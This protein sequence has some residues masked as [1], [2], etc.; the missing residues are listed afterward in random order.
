M[1][2]E[3]KEYLLDAVEGFESQTDDVFA[4]LDSMAEEMAE[5]SGCKRLAVKAKTLAKHTLELV[6]LLQKKSEQLQD[7]LD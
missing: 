3:D 2:H 6:E 7:Q 5:T 4:T 1:T